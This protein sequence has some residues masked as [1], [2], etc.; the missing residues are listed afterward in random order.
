MA[1]KA[2][3]DSFMD[4]FSAFGQDL[5]MP[6]V[7]IETVLE[8]H[9]KNLEAL[10]KSVSASA[11]GATTL[12][13]RQRDMLEEQLHEIARMA[14]SYQPGPNA[15]EAMERHGEFVRKSFETAVKN[16]SEVAQIVQKSGAE[17]I[18][19]LRQRI[20]DSMDEVRNGFERGK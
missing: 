10:Q 4:M 16:A 14:Q 6:Q 15:Q 7:D 5:K 17:S 2:Q 9:R 1:K 20:R 3:P 11:S 18:E 13:A 8:H 19:I 12:M